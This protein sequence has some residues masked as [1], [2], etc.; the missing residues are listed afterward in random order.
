MDPG[1][2]IDSVHDQLHFLV[3]ACDVLAEQRAMM[4]YESPQGLERRLRE[5]LADWRGLLTRNVTEGRAVLR[6]LLIEPVRFTPV[7]EERRSGYVFEGVI[8]LDRL[9]AGVLELPTKV[10]SPTGF[11]PVFQP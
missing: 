4:P 1:T 8:A 6:T 10:A 3:L 7:T 5:K 2:A 9:L 11:E